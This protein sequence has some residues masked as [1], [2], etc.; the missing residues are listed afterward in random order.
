MTM[1]SL[2]EPLLAALRE[3][4]LLVVW[5]DV[6]FRPQSEWKSRSVIRG[7]WKAAAGP[8]GAI[9]LPLHGLPPLTVLS[10]DP[11]GR[12]VEAF[13]RAQVPLQVIRH[14]GEVPV[15]GQHELLMLG[16]EL[17]SETGL[18]LTWEEVQHVSQHR[19]KA[20]LLGLAKQACEGG[21]LLMIVPKNSTAF[22]RIWDNALASYFQG[23][24]MYAVGDERLP[25]GVTNL[26][27]TPSEVLQ[28]LQKSL[29]QDTGTNTPL[30]KEIQP[31]IGIITALPKEQ[32]AVKAMLLRPSVQKTYTVGLIPARGGG[33]H[34]VA[35]SQAGMG[36]NIA[37]VDAAFM[38]CDYPAIK[39]LIM[40]GIA[41]GVPHPEKPD[42]HVR[43]GDIVVLNEQGV[44]QY[45]LDKESY[46][47]TEHRHNP[48]SPSSRLLQVVKQL[49]ANELHGERPWLAHIARANSL[50]NATRPAAHS[51]K[52]ADTM[53]PSRFIAHPHDPKR[54]ANQ[55]R[56]FIAPIA[57]G[58]KLLKNPHKRDDLRDK[59]SVKAIEMEAAG[60]AHAAWRRQVGYMVIRGIC[61][62]CDSHKNDDW[63]GY[64][65][66]VAAAY[67]R[68]ML[69]GMER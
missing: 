44:I 36:T 3:G 18:L 11:T 68:A 9:A 51:D 13:E 65:A 46:Q 33:Y 14:R 30:P 41:G 29:M 27:G 24:P 66:V 31:T 61:D 50:P 7:W 34:H 22:A 58:N 23:V 45:D 62:Y 55:P 52:L 1:I 48:L 15:A 49:A 2:P 43:L 56:V 17:A 21:A 16:G 20:Y 40:V 28:A 32:A 5:G 19:E 4:R 59:F 53:H 54:T 38:L 47:R 6:P 39:D 37:A 64:A 57:S 69:E 25:T 60:V 67:M 26:N 35:L 8:L 42:E 63:Q 10:L 12:M